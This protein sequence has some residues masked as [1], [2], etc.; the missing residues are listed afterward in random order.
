MNSLTRR[1][2]K[3]GR[4]ILYIPSVKR[5]LIGRP[6]I[7]KLYPG[8]E[9]THPFD[10]A[11]GIDTSGKVPVERISPDPQLR[12]SIVPYMASQPGIIRQ[13][14]ATLGNVEDYGFADLGCG[15]G[16]VT[17]VGSEF[18][19]RAIMGVELSPDLA[20]IART[21]AGIVAR[22]FPHRAKIDIFEANAVDYSFPDGKL[23]VFMY[24]SFGRELVSR[25][26]KKFESRLSSGLTHLFFVYY[27]PV[28]GDLFDASPAF[29]R[30]YA[31]SIPYD[32]SEI[33][34]G[35]DTSDAVI[36]WQSCAG[37]KETPYNRAVRPIIVTKHLWRADLAP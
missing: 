29:Q 16:R 21:N 31:E 24:H 22:N 15:K 27:N 26:V 20:E 11:Y 7:G 9:R 4:R 35:P 33:G 1:F 17:I 25:L 6:F 34:Y 5:T 37:A 10:M 18:P 8:L 36:I 13:A 28:H 12:M 32:A 19:F 3:L 2:R 23:V 30:W 14:L